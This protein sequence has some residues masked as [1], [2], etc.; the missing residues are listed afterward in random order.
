MPAPVRRIVVA[1]SLAL[2]LALSACA[3]D[4]SSPAAGASGASASAT[5]SASAVTTTGAGGALTPS[6]AATR[7]SDLPAVTLALAGDANTAWTARRVLRDGVGPMSEYLKR[8]DVAALTLETLVVED[9]SGLVA[10]KKNFTFVTSPAFVDRLAEAGVDVANAANNH[11]MDYK[12][13]GMRRMLALKLPIG[14]VGVG[15]TPDAAFTPWR[16]TVRGR[17]VVVVGGNDVETDGLDWGARD[18][19]PGQAVI[20]RPA[21]EKRLV[22]LVRSE[23]AKDPDA[24]ILAFLHWGQ[25]PQECQSARQEQ[26]ARDISAAGADVIA[27]SHSHRQQPYTTITSPGGRTTAVAYGLGNFVFN[28][29]S[30]ASSRTGVLEVTVPGSGAPTAQ[31]HPARIVD[32]IPKPLTGEAERA[33]VARWELGTA[34]CS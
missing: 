1:A 13:E 25:E 8:A 15:A 6:A 4:A 31:W 5:A 11:T 22:E 34:R 16:T 27:G 9:E 28:T 29:P 32:G 3:R 30:V 23:R 17:N 10:E 18:D 26:L 20:A 14:I 2:P 24:V 12:V 21:G 7:S 19:R 33:E